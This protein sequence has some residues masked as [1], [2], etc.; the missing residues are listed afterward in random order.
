M[1]TFCPRLWNEVFINQNGNVYP[2]CHE[3]PGIIGNIYTARLADIINSAAA[4]RHRRDSLSSRLRCYPPCSILRK[5]KACAS[6]ETVHADYS[7]L[8]RLKILFGERC[9]LDCIMCW[10]DSR[11]RKVLDY[12]ALTRNVDLYPFGSV[13]IQGGEP[14]LIP[15]AKRFFDY[16]VSKGKKPSFLTNGTLITPEWADKIGRHSLF[17][18]VSIN[19]A[20]KETHE[21]V[22]RGSTWKTVLTNIRRVRTAR[23]RYRSDLSILGHM[24]I[25]ERNLAE[26]P[27][28][29]GRFTN[30]GFD[31]IE[32]GYD[33][34][35]PGLL[36]KRPAEMRALRSGIR[37]ELS[38]S[39]SG[40]QVD[41]YRLRLL[42]LM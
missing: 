33:A 37:H 32:F 30:L 38:R 17:L 15:E 9:N 26:I 27:L 29:I 24:T 21:F 4:K 2:C 39:R 3:R 34:R 42:G 6:F 13:E 31:K 40:K 25:V 22:N 20:T 5:S 28:F 1:S 18:H 11:S 36:R 14:L 7:R 19:A 35:V 41:V 23:D 16:A 12:D 8:K 10:Q